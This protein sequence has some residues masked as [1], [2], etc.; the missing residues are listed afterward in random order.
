MPG[1]ML[2]KGKKNPIGIGVGTH[3][4]KQLICHKKVFITAAWVINSIIKGLSVQTAK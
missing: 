2:V 1:L 3:K 4:N